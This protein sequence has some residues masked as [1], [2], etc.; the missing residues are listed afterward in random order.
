VKGLEFALLGIKLL[1]DEGKRV[2]WEIVGEGRER[3]K[4]GFM[5]HALGLS[6]VVKLIGKLDSVQVKERLE[7]CDVFLLPSLSEGISNSAL[8]AMA[9]GLPVISTRS[10]GMDEVISD[11]YSGIL[12]NCYAP[13]EVADGIRKLAASPEMRQ[14][15]GKNARKAVMDEFSVERQILC[16]VSEY[17]ASGA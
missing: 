5:I 3:E 8:E 13:A 1:T 4:L 7:N 17:G 16:F 10:G 2:V 12:V 11:G 15:L 6:E 14:T 9:M